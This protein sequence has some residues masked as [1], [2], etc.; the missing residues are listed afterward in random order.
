V[1]FWRARGCLSGSSAHMF[2]L[3]SDEEHREGLEQ[4]MKATVAYFR[5]RNHFDTRHVQIPVFPWSGLWPIGR[6]CASLCPAAFTGVGACY[7]P[8]LE[9]QAGLT[10][11]LLIRGRASA[12]DFYQTRNASKPRTH[13]YTYMKQL[14]G[15]HT[16]TH[17][18]TCA[19]T[20]T[21][22]HTHTCAHIG[23]SSGPVLQR[24]LSGSGSIRKSN[25]P[26]KHGTGSPVK[27]RGS[28]HK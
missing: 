5:I 14:T 8:Y 19:H 7:R 27:Q 3:V 17:T 6:S 1:P 22:T 25:T 16:H 28:F 4:A 13:T 26:A 9:L 18:H 10:S 2:T 21:R 11:F 24:K 23:S 12:L 15:A 20:H